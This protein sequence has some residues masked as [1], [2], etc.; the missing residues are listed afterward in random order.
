MSRP[1]ILRF[2]S[3]YLPAETGTRLG[4]PLAAGL[5]LLAVAWAAL[6]LPALGRSQIVDTPVYQ[7]Y[8]ERIADGQVPYRDF[9]VEYPPAALPVFWLPTL[10]PEEHYGSVFEALMWSCAWAA[11]A[12]AVLAATALRPRPPR[13]YAAAAFAGLAPLALGSVVLTRYD[14]WPAALTAAALAA[15]VR[16][17]ERIGFGA[18]AL[19]AAAKLYPLALL[20]LAVAYAWRRR[21][22]REAVLGVAVFLAVVAVVVGP[23]LVVAPAG[24]AESVTGQL[25]RPL[26]VESLGAGALLAAHLLGAYEATVVSTHGSQNLAGALPDALAT[27]QTVV[28]ALA[29]V[30]VW[31]LFARA[32]ADRQ[33]LVLACATAVAGFVAFGKVLSPQFLVWLVPLVPLVAGST[34]LAAAALLGAAL[35]TTQVW[36]PTRY[37]DVVALEPVAWLVLVRD[38]VLVALFAVLVLAL[39]RR[40]RAGPRTP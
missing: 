7:E 34:G 32:R 14:F 10:A 1:T 35:V 23:F 27:A 22:P 38:V 5:L 25:G 6:H 24:L 13:L 28:A 39:A 17:R 33:R 31:T 36:F 15:F 3:S 4:P 29:L 21:G 2:E 26:Q 19:A 20:P 18:L 16:D 11:V 30:A 40:A 8:G 37:W 9:P 12:L